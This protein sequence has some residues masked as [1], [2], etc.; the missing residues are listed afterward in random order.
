MSKSVYPKAT[1]KECN[2]EEMRGTFGVSTKEN[3]LKSMQLY[4][5]A[6]AD[7]VHCM[8]CGGIVKDKSFVIGGKQ[9]G[10]SY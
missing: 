5:I 10:I 9:N 3:L 7:T 6:M 2:C 4:G 8:T 1:D